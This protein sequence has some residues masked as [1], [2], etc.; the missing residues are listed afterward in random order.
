MKQHPRE[1]EQRRGSRTAMVAGACVAGLFV[2]VVGWAALP[3]MTNVSDLVGRPATGAVKTS[4]TT[5]IGTGVPS[6][7]EAESRV[8]KDDPAGLEDSTGGRARRIKQT[9]T[10]LSLSSQQR[11]RL[12]TILGQQKLPRSD[13]SNFELM[14]GTAV[15][16]QTEVG[17][18][19]PEATEVLNGYWGDQSLIVGNSLVIVDQHTRRV[20]A[21]I[22]GMT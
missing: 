18:L 2:A 17:D 10:A 12:R 20:V 11:D 3:W 21:I 6:Q 7:S 14:I 19:P 9:S 16:R 5:G 8:G 22:A 1:E 13:R 4:T 15:P